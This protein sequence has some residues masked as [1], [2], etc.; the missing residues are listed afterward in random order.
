MAERGEQGVTRGRT[1]AAAAVPAATWR[2]WGAHCPEAMCRRIA[3]GEAARQAPHHWPQ[4]SHLCSP[5]CRLPTQRR[6]QQRLLARAEQATAERATE[7]DWDSLG[8]GLTHV[9]SVRRRQAWH[10]RCPCGGG[11][12][13]SLAPALAPFLFQC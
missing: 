8:F 6:Q 2:L 10:C 11:Q 12:G 3:Q 1:L 9:G 4:S 7:F 5:C 13:A